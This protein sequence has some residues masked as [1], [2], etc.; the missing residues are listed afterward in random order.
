M[1]PYRRTTV[2]DEEHV[3]FT[4]VADYIA[5]Q[6]ARTLAKDRMRLGQAHKYLL[7]AHLEALAQG[8]GDDEAVRFV[9]AVLDEFTIPLT[10]PQ[11]TRADEQAYRRML[12]VHLTQPVSRATRDG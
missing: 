8:M 2:T 5:K 3:W 12:R 6:T 9:E 7:I 10:P 11:R 1:S 4:H